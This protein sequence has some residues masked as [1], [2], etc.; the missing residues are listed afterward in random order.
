[1]EVTATNTVVVVVFGP[2]G[3]ALET[4]VKKCAILKYYLLSCV[5]IAKDQLRSD[6]LICIIVSFLE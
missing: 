5:P 1:M 2:L 3:K 6:M 4:K